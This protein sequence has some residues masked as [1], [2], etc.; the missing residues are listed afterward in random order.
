MRHL[1]L[2]VVVAVVAVGS[3]ALAQRPAGAPTASPPVVL[4]PVVLILD[5]AKG[6]IEIQ[7]FPADAPKSVAHITALV[8][9]GFYRGLRFHRVERALVQAGDP[10]TRD[11]SRSAYWGSGNSGKPIG[12]AEFSKRR[13]VRGTVALAHAGDARQADS[14]FYIMKAPQAAYDGKYT[15]I[16]LVT[17]GMDVV[18]KLQVED[19]I[20][21]A[22]IK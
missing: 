1:S 14:Q 22:T 16:G 4:M 21:T 7:L 13:H 5:T 9:S 18:D 3:A 6:T 11:V 19:V 17:R 8:R 15:I 2:A 20:K 12:A 10:L